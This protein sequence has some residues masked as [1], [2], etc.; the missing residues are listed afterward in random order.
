MLEKHHKHVSY[1]KKNYF[2]IGHLSDDCRKL[3]EELLY[4]LK[5]PHI[6]PEKRTNV[7]KNFL[8]DITTGTISNTAATGLTVLL[9]SLLTHIGL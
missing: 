2:I 8:S 9:S 7:I 1:E 4:E 6:T 5:N 3:I